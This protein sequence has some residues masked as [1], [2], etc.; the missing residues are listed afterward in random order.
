M[1]LGLKGKRAIVTGGSRGI[2]RA[3]LMALVGDGVKVATCARGAEGLDRIAAD[4]SAVGGT[5]LTQALD[6]RDAGAFE[7]WLHSAAE[8]L[9][10]VDIV[11]S[12]VS[13][14]VTVTGD[15]MW[16]ETFETDL[17]Q[18]VRLAEMTLPHL[19]KGSEPA[20]VFISSIASVLTQLPPGEEAYG[21][22]KAALV[23]YAGQLSA[24]YGRKGLRVNTVS[25]GPIY[26]EGGV[27]DQIRQHQ[28]ALFEAAARLSVLER[29][30]TAE[31]VARAVAFLA[32]P[33]AS[34]ITGANL[35]I[36]GGMIK[37]ANF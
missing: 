37:T 25:P 27:W 33:A 22:M 11:I 8:T 13:T 31:E 15:Q 7:T 3:I 6:V 17:L 2:G 5:V 26:F 21:T 4:A 35:R 36:D 14:R 1:D 16:R 24:R 20:L 32:S 18:H 30:G 23:N 29:H 19:L 9:G 34:Y 28:P 12:N 10:G